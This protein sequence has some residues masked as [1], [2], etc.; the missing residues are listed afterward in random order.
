MNKVLHI[1]IADDHPVVLS[2]LKNELCR[3]P[4]V[5][6]ALEAVTGDTLLSLL[7]ATP[8]E[9]VITDFAM[10]HEMSGDVDGFMLIKRI[11]TEHPSS[12]VIVYTAMSNV[13]VVKRLY[14][15]GV[16]SVINKKEHAD[17]L[18]GACL[19]TQTNKQ[20]YFPA[21]L[22][23]EL[24]I[25]WAQGNSFMHAKDLTVSEL[26]VVRLFVEGNSLGDICELL[27]RTPSTVSTHKNNAMRK[28]G[29]TTDADLIK[30]AYSSGMI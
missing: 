14:Q 27:S 25:G 10:R 2:A 11:K 24:E 12:K 29:L 13:A 4:E 28:L 15:I 17:E 1:A 21:S 8:C 19:A 30:Y 9:I 26:E 23:G 7:R 18:I 22:R 16:F 20:A 6:I 5:R 3:L